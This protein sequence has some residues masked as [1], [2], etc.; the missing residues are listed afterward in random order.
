MLSNFLR[1]VRLALRGILRRPGFAAAVIGTLALGIGANTA[2][3]TVVRAVLLRS[4]PFAHAER[5]VAIHSVEP[6]SDRQ[7]FS[8]AD[9]FDLSEANRS[10]E[11]LLAYGSWSANLTGVDEPV[12]IPDS[13]SRAGSST[14]SGCAPRSGGRRGP[15]KRRPEPRAS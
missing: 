1:D 9:F 10:F 12:S 4:L 13:G 2:I 3:F 8:I 14:P 5:L 15:K 6:G 7:P 11:A